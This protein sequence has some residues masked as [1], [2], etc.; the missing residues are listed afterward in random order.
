MS[1]DTENVRSSGNTG[2]NRRPVKSTRMTQ[3]RH[4]LPR[5]LGGPH[6]IRNAPSPVAH[7]EDRRCPASE[8]GAMDALAER[9]TS[10]AYEKRTRLSSGIGTVTQLTLVTAGIFHEPSRIDGSFSFG[11]YRRSISWNL[12]SGAGSQLDSLSAPGES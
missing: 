9:K 11:Q 12:P 8:S 10:S 1:T 7:R 2:S 3:R 5:V 4:L 6:H